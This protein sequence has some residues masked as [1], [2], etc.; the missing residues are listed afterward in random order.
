MI[1]QLQ[2]F[3]PFSAEVGKCIFHRYAYVRIISSTVCLFEVYRP[4][5][6]YS[7]VSLETTLL[8]VMGCLYLALMAI[9]RSVG[10]F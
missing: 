8:P 7:V 2:L 4:T 6:E 5:R 3:R 10:V 1:G 9:S